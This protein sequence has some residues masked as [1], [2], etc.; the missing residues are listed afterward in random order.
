V[1]T[2]PVEIQGGDTLSLKGYSIGMIDWNYRDL[3]PSS[4][5][6]SA[7][8]VRVSDDHE[9]LGYPEEEDPF[10]QPRK[11]QI[12]G[13]AWAPL[14]AEV[15]DV[16]II[17][18]RTTLPLVLRPFGE[19]W[20]FVGHC[21]FLVPRH[22]MVEKEYLNRTTDYHPIMHGNAWAE[23]STRAELQEFNLV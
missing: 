7:N 18:K 12:S 22:D 9:V 11:E 10:P 5:E 3:H 8:L 13:V 20:L 15:G 19:S 4:P 1:L 17:A 14:W 2:F 16:V 23:I 6:L 21:R